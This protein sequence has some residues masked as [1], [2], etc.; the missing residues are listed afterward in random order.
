MTTP[1]QAVPNRDANKQALFQD[2]RTKW[3]K[4]S[5]SDI[6]ALK[7]KD[8][9]VAQVVAKYGQEKGLVQRE[10]DTLLKGRAI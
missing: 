10:V 8:D 7:D 6:A 2:I 9:L 3:D 1:S 5:E 4:F